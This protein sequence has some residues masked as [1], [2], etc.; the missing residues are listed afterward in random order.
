[1]LSVFCVKVGVKYGPEYVNRLRSMVRR[2]L[3][4]PHR[5]VCATDT[6]EG[7]HGDVMTVTPRR[8]CWGW[9]N[10]MEAYSDPSWADGPIWY[11]GLDTVITGNIDRAVEGLQGLT[12]I[13]D[14]SCLMEDNFT[15]PLFQNVWAD[16]IAYIPEG[17]IPLVWEAF[18]ENVPALCTYP[19]HVWL[20]KA[21]RKFEITPH[22][23]QTIRPDLL[24]SFKWPEPKLE[25]PPEPI[26]CF[27]GEPRPKDVAH[28]EW[29]KEHWRE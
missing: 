12:L 19:M 9:W 13:D 11:T 6:V 3:T 2:N 8:E 24:C 15:N 25:Q 20:T 18:L 17:G 28:L 7:L 26:V 22:I 4:V 1:M 27:H 23:Y 29:I 5:F 14:F 21:L 10:L 16:G